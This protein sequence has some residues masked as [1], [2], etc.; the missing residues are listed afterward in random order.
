MVIQFD[1]A[2]KLRGGVAANKN[3]AS[4]TDSLGNQKEE[5]ARHQDTYSRRGQ[6]VNQVHCFR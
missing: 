2:E 3:R 6:G 4:E 5:R 1:E